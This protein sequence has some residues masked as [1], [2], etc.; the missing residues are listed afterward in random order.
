[1]VSSLVQKE[2][3]Y[4][5]SAYATRLI[6]LDSPCANKPLLL[7]LL[8]C[9]TSPFFLLVLLSGQQKLC[10]PEQAAPL[11]CAEINMLLIMKT[12][13][14][15]KSIFLIY[16]ELTEIIRVLIALILFTSSV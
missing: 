15:V 14:K 8:Y 9:Q 1:M 12:A 11:R 3:M 7:W 10:S 6:S 16:Y 2:S 13:P 5:V 4:S